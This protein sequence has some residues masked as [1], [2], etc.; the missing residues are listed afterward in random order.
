MKISRPAVKSTQ[1]HPKFR[2]LFKCIDKCMYL[3]ATQDALESLLCSA[4]FNPAIP[5]NLVGAESLGIEQ[6]LLADG[7]EYD[8]L[9]KAIANRVPYLTFFWR[10]VVHNAQVHPL[11]VLALKRLPPICLAV[12]FWTNTVQSFLQ[13]QYYSQRP[14]SEFI[15][16]AE[17]FSIS[18]YCRNEASV[19]WTPSPP[20]GGTN[21]NNLSLDIRSHHGHNHWPRSW[22]NKWVLLSGEKVTSCS[23]TQI[24]PRLF[25]QPYHHH[26]PDNMQSLEYVLT[27][28]GLFVDD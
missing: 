14:K 6:A 4:F 12:A 18:F 15:S 5:C 2:Q 20:F 27:L 24:P 28:I 1:S 11:L 19:P 25:H 17:E 22:N 13:V 23:T 3:S 9:L 26:H 16:R 21:I 8:A 10:A 7:T